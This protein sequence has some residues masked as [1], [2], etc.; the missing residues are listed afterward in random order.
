MRNL[1]ALIHS[2]SDAA[3][4]V[5][6]AN[7]VITYVNQG[8]TRLFGYRSEEVVGRVLDSLLVGARTD[9]NTLL[10]LRDNDGA[11]HEGAGNVILLY[12]KTG[13][14]IWVAISINRTCDAQGMMTGMM[15]IMADV[16]A[17]K[18]Y[19]VLQRTI[20]DALAH[21]Q[22]LSEVMTLL[23]QEVENLAPDV[24]ATVV[25]VD[26]KQCLHSLASPSLPDWYAECVNGLA[27]GPNQASCGTAA[28]L[29]QA[30]TVVDIATDPAWDR[31]RELVLPLGLKACWSNP[32]KS[33]DGRVLGS[34]AFYFREAQEPDAFHKI[35]VSSCLPLCEL[36]FEREEARAHIRQLAFFDQLT[37]LANRNMLRVEAGGMIERIRRE[38]GK[39]AV[40]FIDLD[41]FKTIND[42]QGHAVGNV[43]LNQVALRLNSSVRAI[44]LVARAGGDE[45]V[46]VLPDCD[47][48]QVANVAEKMLHALSLPIDLGGG[49]NVVTGASIGVAL[50]PDDG[51]DVDTLMLHAD[52]AM[53]QA[54]HEGRAR[55]CFFHPEMKHRT[56][57]R[58][59]LEHALGDAI[60]TGGLAL[61]YQPKVSS[62]GVLSGVEALLRWEHPEL[63]EIPASRFISLAEE[64]NLIN[65]LSDWTIGEAC[66]Q[67]AAWQREGIAVP[68]IAINVSV[69]DFKHRDLASVLHNALVSNGLQPDQLV[70]EMTESVMFDDT[71]DTLNRIQAVRDLGVSLAL[72]DFGTGYSSL[73]YLHRLSVNEIKI[74][75]SFVRDLTPGSKSQALVRAMLGIGQSLGLTVVAEG[76]ETEAQRD[77]LLV[78][79]CQ[80]LQGYFYSRPL[81][82]ADFVAWMQSRLQV[83]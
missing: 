5:A 80:V 53:Y 30:V 24:T 22:P 1:P 19:E 66:R 68:H 69:L 54:K 37:G 28:W 36:A 55:L 67:L 75:R 43:V 48:A 58:I 65:A 83:A 16:T 71:P 32:I 23:C 14:P 46:A 4:M 74:D 21:E 79:G 63:G 31:Y 9:M 44:D 25:K 11:E 78:N 52:M 82:P 49:A 70:L 50:Y 60:R 76:V 38:C 57:E 59:A 27:I 77:F 26:E 33:H 8:F 12:P 45:F 62:L 29:G 64:A 18:T 10:R 35:L 39:L 47:G 56:R 13:R 6:D 41:R 42:T 17:S 40:L 73:S 2:S 15:V 51:D 72:D 3:V 34:F 81:P 7:R 20:L 61:H